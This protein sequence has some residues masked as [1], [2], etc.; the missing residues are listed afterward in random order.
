MGVSLTR[1]VEQ[2]EARKPTSEPEEEPLGVTAWRHGQNLSLDPETCVRILRES[3]YRTGSVWLDRI[4]DGLSAE[5]LTTFLQEHGAE[6]C[7]GLAP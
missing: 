6:L 5:E 7:A 2:L 3:G 4:P 1:R